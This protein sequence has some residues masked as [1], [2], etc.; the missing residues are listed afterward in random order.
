M[1]FVKLS[2]KLGDKY[3]FLCLGD[4]PDKE[5]FMQVVKDDNIEDRFIILTARD[6]V[7]KYYSAMDLFAM[8]SHYEGLPIV[9]VEAQ[10]NG[11]SCVLSDNISRQTN[12][13]GRCEFVAN[14][15]LIKWAETVRNIKKDRF[16]GEQVLKENGFSI[17]N[18]VSMVEKIFEQI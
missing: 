4:G 17:Y 6:D 9:A 5:P 7:Y 3:M 8:P 11:L 18:T 1:Y 15:D 16:D 14:D 2:K 12:I 13:T 10:C